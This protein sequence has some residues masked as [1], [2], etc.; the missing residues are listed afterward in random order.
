MSFLL[1]YEWNLLYL[2]NMKE[3]YAEFIDKLKKLFGSFDEEHK[4]F[5]KASNSEI[6]R[7]LGYSDAQFSRLINKSATEGEYHRALQNVNRILRVKKLE[8]QVLELGGHG[9]NWIKKPIWFFAFLGVL[10]ISFFAIY[11][12][13]YDSSLGDT[14]S[15]QPRDAMLKWTFETSFVNPYT[16]LDDLPD[17][18]NYPCYKYQ[19]KWRLKNGY[20]IPFF[21]ERSG[22]HYSAIEVNMYARCMSE[23]SKKGD[24]MEGYEYQ[25]HEIWY[26]QRELPIDSFLLGPYGERSAAYQA[27]NFSE[28]PNFIKVATLHT[29]FRNEFLIDSTMIYRTGKVIGRDM[30]ITS[31]AILKEQLGKEQLVND[32]EYEL[33]QIAA[34]RLEDFSIP[35][36][37]EPSQ[38]PHIDF[39]QVNE[40]DEM[41]F[42][43]ELTTSRVPFS[44]T[45]IFTLEQQYIKNTCRSLGQ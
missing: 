12:I 22:F 11:G 40:G 8:D 23:E 16:K 25:K 27:L 20:K 28:D 39:H 36:S 15:P 34:N 29:F 18:C 1:P 44:Y 13:W 42:D 5:Q 41:V 31:R 9:R 45:K 21:R 32:I 17:D 14:N 6:S 30:E 2:H 37:C 3:L 24:I 7:E 35:I 26:D 33:N 10:I 38:V 19:G 4:R 43:C